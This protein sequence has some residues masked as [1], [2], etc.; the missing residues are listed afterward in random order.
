MTVRIAHI[1]DLHV[2][3]EKPHFNANLA[4]LFDELGRSRPDIL[5]NTGDL[6]LY[7]EKD[8]GDLAFAKAAHQAS[9]I[10]FHIT[11]GNHDIGEHPAIPKRVHVDEASLARYRAKIGP[12]S[13]VLDLPGWRLV[14]LNSLIVGTGLSGD[15]EQLEMLRKASADRA[16]RALALVMH[17][18]LA[19]LDYADTSVNGR[20]TTHGSRQLPCPSVSRQPDGWKPAYLGTG[21]VI[22]DRRSVAADLWRQGARLSGA[23]VPCGWQPCL[24]AEDRPRSR[25]P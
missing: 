12:D 5:L 8:N 19:D 13:W 15:L 9:G 17:K 2:S 4:T 20:F 22:R 21:R 10:T 23:S 25:P 11:P 6:G 7:G 14:G 1:S 18:P 24:S 3:P 16:G